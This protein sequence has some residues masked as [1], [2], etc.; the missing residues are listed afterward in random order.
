[1][2]PP[3]S[4]EMA[5]DRRRR[6]RRVG[7][8]TAAIAVLV[9]GAAVLQHRGA[10]RLP[11]ST[12]SSPE[13]VARRLS[14]Q[15]EANPSNSAEWLKL[16]LL[17]EQRGYYMAAVQSF[18]AARRLGASTNETAG[19]LGRCLL[20][21]KRFPEALPELESAAREQPESVE[22]TTDLAQLHVESGDR[23]RAIQVLEE[24]LKRNP[25]V[26]TGNDAGAKQSVE[27]LMTAFGNAGD[28]PRCLELARRLIALDSGNAGGYVIAGRELL[29][30]NR[31][32]EAVEPLETAV[33]LAPK[34]GAIQYLFGTALTQIP[35]RKDE[36]LDQLEQ[37]SRLDERAPGP[38][39]ALGKEY[40]RKGAW[41]QAAIAYL[42]ATSLG[43]A[44]PASYARAAEL[45]DQ[46][47]LK[48]EAI[49][50]RAQSANLAFDHTR[51]LREFL[52]LSKET[53]PLWRE[54]GLDGGAKCYLALRRTPEYLALMEKSAAGGTAADWLRLAQAYALLHDPRQVTCLQRAQERDPK[55]AG[56]VHY[57]LGR[58]AEGDSRWDDVER[59]FAAAIAA[60]DQ[61]PENH[62][63]LSRVYLTRRDT[64]DRSARAAQEAE[65]AV[66]LEPGNAAGYHLLGTARVA[67][68]NSAG[69]VEALQHA[70]DLNPDDGAAYL[71]LANLLLQQGERE[72]GEELQRLYR[73]RSAL[74]LEKRNLETRAD[75]AP[76]DPV[77][78]IALGDF[79]FRTH[80]YAHAVEEFQRAVLL[81][82][83]DQET[84]HKLI[85]AYQRLGRA[86]EAAE[87]K[88]LLEGSQKEPS[89]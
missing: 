69:G 71:D 65:R 4:P 40:A 70:I 20:R 13:D 22:A 7:W 26:L 61:N 62:R 53:N 3:N 76:Q 59:E 36:A 84:R 56:Q 74:D 21:L 85:E 77:A 39:Y 38:F 48:A 12:S 52:R 75:A 42:T 23:R 30:L 63:S 83:H 11:A 87:Q 6:W 25:A 78:R 88:R 27:R 5:D 19:P 64:G 41:R 43:D 72:R 8:L 67:A 81:R 51:S 46:A 14:K 89:R 55:V 82:P 57:A 31:P 68:G 49:Y 47:G 15:V 17:D 37:S 2:P 80:D 86:G 32:E 34:V 73:E 58:L 66:A 79:L 60:E 50:C 44:G 9:A 24:F 18:R 54:R 29:T 35:D 28:H 33:S 16:G 1:M 45:C 10:S